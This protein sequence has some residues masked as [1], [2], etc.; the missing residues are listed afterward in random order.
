M[1]LIWKYVVV[2]CFLIIIDQLT[3]G[4][5]QSSFALGEVKPVINGFFNFTYVQNPGAAFGFLANSHENIRRPLFLFLPLIACV[6]IAVLLW[7]TRENNKIL[8]WAYTLILAGAIGNLI[9]RFSMGYVVDFLDFY[10]GDEHFPAFN[11]A[12]SAITIA[13]FLLIWDFILEFKRAKSATKGAS[14]SGENQ[15]GS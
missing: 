10:L 1:K 15:A 6:W 2:I 12:D 5:V 3:K 9:D 14:A 7:K 13:A 11:V 8:A 4:A